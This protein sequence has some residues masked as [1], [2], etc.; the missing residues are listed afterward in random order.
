VKLAI[1]NDDTHAETDRFARCFADER[2]L[3]R[4]RALHARVMADGVASISTADDPLV[5]IGMETASDGRV[6]RNCYGVFGLSWQAAEHPEWAA[7]VVH[8]VDRVRSRIQQAHGVPLRFLIWAGMGG[9]IE[10]KTMYHAAG[11][12]RGGPIFYPLDSTDPAKLNA[13][14]D[15][16]ERRSQRPLRQALP[17][18]LVVGMALGM[19]S[20]EP[21]VNLEKLSA[22]FD[23]FGIN[24]RSNFVYL[25]LPGSLLDQFASVR[26][27]QRVP[28]QM[29]GD[30]TTAGRHSGPLTRGALYPLALAGI[31]IRHWIRSTRL[32]DR[33]VATAWK[34]SSFLH[35]QGVAGRDKVTLALPRAWSGA[36]VWTKQDFEESLGKS[37]ALGIKIVVGEQSRR[38]YY[39]PANDSR[40][41]RVFLTIRLGRGESG[42]STQM[43]VRAG[44]PLAV[45]EMPAGTSLS[46]YM[47]FMHYAVFGVAYLRAMNF[48]T[49]PSVELYKTI[50]GEI[51]AD[52][53]RAGSVSNTSAWCSMIGSPRQSS[54]RRRLTV[55]YDTVNANAGAGDAAAM[56]A[57]LIRQLHANRSIE[58]GDL[59]FFGD[60]R[61]G[62]EGRAMRA[63]LERGA[64][65]VFRRALRMPV[66]VYEGPAMNHSYHEMIIGHGRCFSTV[67]LSRRQASIRSVNYASEYH[68]SQFLATRM[69]LARRHRPVVAIVVNDMSERSR[70]AVD[71]FFGAVARHLKG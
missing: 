42:W 12:L 32:D 59:T 33:D 5:S 50:A 49:Q 24:S 4:L 14:V 8:E 18:T 38:A 71:D 61:L 7:Q 56:Y 68:V 1:F 34:L 20:Y 54:W 22:L 66:D 3:P 51:Y 36:G 47:Q 19:T 48:V 16:L 58:Y 13:I 63:A 25:T 11:L 23:R 21:V 31:D 41:D 62:S 57:S 37:E 69:A 45:V 60:L 43:L 29:D 55:Y 28:L 40:Q 53:K 52:A 67:L 10:D 9:S 39:H 30:H 27:Y 2:V 65:R 17:A 6:T 35:A 44:Y 26:G 15:D 46:R 64:D 70:A